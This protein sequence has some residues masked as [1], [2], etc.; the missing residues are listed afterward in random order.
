MVL[1]NQIFNMHSNRFLK[2]KCIFFLLF[3]LSKLV[4]VG[5]SR[6]I[7]EFFYFEHDVAVKCSYKFST[8]KYYST[9]HQNHNG[10]VYLNSI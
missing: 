8:F 2:N 1:T 4:Q 5:E 7:I 9:I 6:W 3:R 10:K